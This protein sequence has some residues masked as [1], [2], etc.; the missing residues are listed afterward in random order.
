[1]GVVTKSPIQKREAGIATQDP[2]RLPRRREPSFCTA[3]TH[4]ASETVATQRG[5]GGRSITEGGTLGA[6][7]PMALYNGLL[8]LRASCRI[9]TLRTS[10]GLRSSG[11]TAQR[12]QRL[13]EQA[14]CHVLG[15]GPDTVPQA[16][17]P[18]T[19]RPLFRTI[20]RSRHHHRCSSSVGP[21]SLRNA[22]RRLSTQVATSN[23]SCLSNVHRPDQPSSSFA[24]LS[25][26]PSSNPS[27]SP[28]NP[29]PNAPPLPSNSTPFSPSS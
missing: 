23:P 19:K 1:M 21:G 12:V 7:T 20:R 9:S 25:S 22:F 10:S 17:R 13:R 16:A 14:D 6:Q 15:R 28:P 3:C 2:N 18:S 27:L 29:T 5:G 24:I 26:S 11:S 8:V 4:S